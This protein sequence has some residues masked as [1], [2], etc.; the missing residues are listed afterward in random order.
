MQL[1]S[2]GAIVPER[3]LPRLPG[4]TRPGSSGFEARRAEAARGA[5]AGRGPALGRPAAARSAESRRLR[6]A[7][8]EFEAILIK[9]MLDVMRKTVPKTG[10]LGGGM[11]EE[12]FED[13]LY[14]EYAKKMAETAHFGLADMIVRQLEG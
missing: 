7:A 9:Q 13:M 3:P 5:T 2:S 12:I 10:L 4:S 14:D 1:L 8:V 11:A 6:Q